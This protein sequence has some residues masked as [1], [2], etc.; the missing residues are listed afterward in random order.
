MQNQWRTL[1]K[2]SDHATN[3][4]RYLSP[5]CKLEGK[6][7]SLLKKISI[8]SERKPHSSSKAIAQ[9]FNGQFTACFV[10]H[11]RALRRF[12]RDLHRHHHVGPS[13]RPFNETDVAAAIRKA[14]SYTTQGTDGLT[15]LHPHFSKGFSGFN[16]QKY[17]SRIIA[18]P[19]DISKASETVSHRPYRDDPLLPTPT[20]FGEVACGIPPWQEGLIPLPATIKLTTVKL[21]KFR[22]RHDFLC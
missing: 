17:L 22:S 19:V 5:L 2:S 18:I 8:S 10:Q 15:V 3:P 7:S 9:A 13:F 1:L 12:T 11:D 16:Q 14:G 4:K 21:P 6:R 20:Q